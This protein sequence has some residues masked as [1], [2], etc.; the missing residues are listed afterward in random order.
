MA[1]N[2]KISEMI[3]SMEII[4]KSNINID[5]TVGRATNTLLPSLLFF[6][7]SLRAFSSLSALLIASIAFL[8]SCSGDSMPVSLFRFNSSSIVGSGNAYN[9][10]F[11]PLLSGGYYWFVGVI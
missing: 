11:L 9:I 6:G 5:R 10:F 2:A 7:F 1:R 8:L 3:E 4:T